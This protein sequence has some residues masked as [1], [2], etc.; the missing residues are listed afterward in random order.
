MRCNKCLRKI[1]DEN[2]ASSL[3]QWGK[4]LCDNCGTC[5]HGAALNVDCAQCDAMFAGLLA[6]VKCNFEITDGNVADP[7]YAYCGHVPAHAGDHG[8]WQR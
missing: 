5:S 6:D 4:A 1:T 2:P 8:P 7:S 3:D